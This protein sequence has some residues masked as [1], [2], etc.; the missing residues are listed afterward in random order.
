L[1]ILRLRKDPRVSRVSLLSE[2]LSAILSH[3]SP[4]RGDTCR[5]KSANGTDGNPEK[6]SAHFGDLPTKKND[7][8]KPGLQD[9]SGT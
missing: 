8:K 5:H 4:E 9:H 6:K 1:G 7:G 3:R 2:R